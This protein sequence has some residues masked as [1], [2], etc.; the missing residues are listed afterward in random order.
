MLLHL[1][2]MDG[3]DTVVR[4][5][6]NYAATTENGTMPIH[7]ASWEGAHEA[8][9]RVLLD[10]GAINTIDDFRRTPLHHALSSENEG[11][12]GCS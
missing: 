12:C 7:L 8:V 3:H 6:L 11:V 4:L 10:S 1:A 9:V 5:L 2:A